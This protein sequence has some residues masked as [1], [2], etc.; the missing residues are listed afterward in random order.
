[1]SFKLCQFGKT[2]KQDLNKANNNKLSKKTYTDLPN[3][4]T[5]ATAMGF[6]VVPHMLQIPRTC[7][8]ILY[9]ISQNLTEAK[10][11]ACIS[12]KYAYLIDQFIDNCFQ[13][14]YLIV[15]FNVIC[16]IM[17]CFKLGFLWYVSSYLTL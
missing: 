14:A 16:H 12:D 17:F 7:T 5:A 9:F 15:H 11:K 3:I 13:Y 4:Y 1:M 6:I 2:L 10:P 8:D